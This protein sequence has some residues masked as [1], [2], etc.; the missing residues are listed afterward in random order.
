MCYSRAVAQFSRLGLSCVA[1]VAL[2]ARLLGAQARPVA[3]LELH[4][5]VVREPRPGHADTFT[6]DAPAGRFVHV[7]VHKHGVDVI[8]FVTAPTGT[9]LPPVN[10][11]NNGFG[12]E[13]ISWI[14]E[15]SGTYAVAVTRPPASTQRGRY[16]IEWQDLRPPTE[17]DLRQIE[18]ERLFSQALA[19]DRSGTKETNRE[20]AALYEKSRALWH[21]LE[22]PYQEALCL[23][24]IAR[25]YH[26]SGDGK[27]AL[28]YDT[29][30]LPLY[31]AARDLAGEAQALNN[32]G[33]VH[34]NFGESQ[35]ALQYYRQALPIRRAAGD[36][37]GEARTLDRMGSVY[38]DLGD[39]KAALEYHLQALS[40]FREVGDR[41]GEAGALNNIGYDY[42]YSGATHKALQYYGRALPIQRAVQDRAGEAQT[43]NNI[44]YIYSKSEHK[45]IA[46]EY[47]GQAL[48]IRELVGYRSDEA[49]TLNNLGMVYS[50]LGQKEKALESFNQALMIFRAVGVRAGE[51][52]VMD[53]LRIEYQASA[54]ALAVLFGKQAINV[55]QSIRRDNRELEPEVRRT[56]EKSIESYYRGLA[57]LLVNLSRFA[58]AEEVLNLLKDKEAADYIRRDSISDQLRPATLLDFEKRALRR[59]DE[60][61]GQIVTMGDR[62]TVLLAKRRQG[63][64]T[65]DDIAELDKLET[66]LSAATIL[67]NRFLAEQEKAFAP[68][69]AL[70][71]QIGDFRRAASVQTSLQKLGPKTVAI[72][73]LVAEDKYVAMLVTGGARKA[74]TT[75]IQ[76]AALNQKLFAFRQALQDPHSN[77]LPLAQ[78]L[79]HILLPEHLRQDLDAIDAHNLLWSMD[80]T[81]RYVPVG[82]LHDGRGFLVER[83]RNSLINPE[84]LASLTEENSG[85]WQ[86]IGF[87]VSEAHPPFSPL[88]AVP[89]ELHRIFRLREVEPA[90]ISG[91]I[92]LDTEFKKTTFTL[93]LASTLHPIVHIA[94]HFD[95]EPGDAANSSLL[96]GDGT[97]LTLAEI[98]ANENLFSDV[99]LVTLSACST[100]FQIGTADGREIDSLGVVAQTVGAKS[101]VASLWNVSDEATAVLMQRFYQNWKEHPE[102]GK[103]EALRVAQTQMATGA[104]APPASGISK[105]R[106]VTRDADAA[107]KS[108]WKHPYYWAPF[109]LIG[110][111]R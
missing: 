18:A 108:E 105:D 64:L 81:L 48:S 1:G 79:Y 43:L 102:L 99:D 4:K 71:K 36:R 73:T 109:V 7:V 75:G 52:Q 88:P 72:Y 32:I 85:K 2:L 6:L 69:S 110:N 25:V 46:L 38:L 20:A 35:R 41:A 47:Y 34:S 40:I 50:A 91:A 78:E 42:S 31:R 111:A 57:S 86:G 28:E 94:T 103:S 76:Q 44:G 93:D 90:P 26:N 11:P 27:K 87:G 23:H 55:L 80:S 61:M 5:P 92:R 95:A 98:A 83:F 30:A 51:A 62:K 12:P 45:Q 21:S 29:E 8:L 9:R 58:E 100:G 101:V 106:G 67:L 15:Q 104:L 82:A 17:R 13:P 66:D 60:I 53:N 77:P 96:L 37:A 89:D 49:Q 74:Y 56:F 68:G 70:S 3:K 97:R 65:S 19:T 33:N 63:E 10:S 16:E 54:P 107:L 39:N 14:T 22:D 84:S 59:Y 24:R